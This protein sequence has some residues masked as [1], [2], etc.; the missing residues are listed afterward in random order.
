MLEKILE[1]YFDNDVLSREKNENWSNSAIPSK[2]LNL[3]NYE[4]I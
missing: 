4:L 1:K 3:I 2:I